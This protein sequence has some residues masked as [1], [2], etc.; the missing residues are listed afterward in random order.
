MNAFED[1]RRLSKLTALTAGLLGLGAF[2]A[3][4]SAAA[5]DFGAPPE[6]PASL[7]GPS[8]TDYI[9]RTIV[10]PIYP[11]YP[12]YPGYPVPPGLPL[13]CWRYGYGGV[14]LPIPPGAPTP[15][16]P[17]TPTPGPAT[18]LSYRVC[19]QVVNRVPAN[20]Q[21]DAVA[22]PYRLYGYGMLQN[23]SV[24]YHPLWNSYRTW[25]TLLD[26]GKPWSPC[27]PVVWKVGCP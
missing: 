3:G 16:P 20:I 7:V 9:S 2:L 1:G 19:P 6:I 17:P 24:P 14:P 23:P 5:A 12:G 27:N 26:Y 25:L 10:I 22:N 13:P 4:W 8:D 18:A 11:G 21:Q 15:K